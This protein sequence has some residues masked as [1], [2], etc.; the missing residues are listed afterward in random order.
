MVSHMALGIETAGSG[1]RVLALL[2]DARLVRW[3]LGTDHALRPARGR[4]A[5]E[6]RQARAD[7]LAL[8]FPALGVGAARRRLAWVNVLRGCGWRG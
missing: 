2:V 1:A 6:L 8:R 4:C 3:A 7:G 5:H